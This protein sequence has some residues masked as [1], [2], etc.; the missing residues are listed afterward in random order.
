[1][2]THRP[3]KV[4]FSF[5]P[6]LDY[7]WT[8]P[9]PKAIALD[10][11][12]DKERRAEIAEDIFKDWSTWTRGKGA[13]DMLAEWGHRA[14]QVLLRTAQVPEEDW[15]KYEGRGRE[16]RLKK[17]RW[18]PHACS[19]R[20]GEEGHLQEG[21]AV[22]LHLRRLITQQRRLEE[23]LRMQSRRSEAGHRSQREKQ[24]TQAILK[25]TVFPIDYT[26][27][28]F[29]EVDTLKT[30]IGRITTEV[31]RNREEARRVRIANWRTKL[32]QDWYGGTRAAT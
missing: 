10:N 5:A 7:Q 31:V 13:A 32:Q 19:V 28:P 3:L 17:K 1:M 2:H 22:S 27:G 11:L 4:G 6:F 26:A 23:L 8:M 24:L 9:R 16:P 20:S 12:V 30:D 14:E 29:N 21:E 15:G 25:E 18:G